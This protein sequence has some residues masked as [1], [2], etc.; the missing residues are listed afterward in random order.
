MKK[1]CGWILFVAFVVAVGMGFRLGCNHKSPGYVVLNVV[2]GD[3]I[4]IRAGGVEQS[5]RLLGVDTPETVHPDIP[6]EPY[7]AEAAEFTKQLLRGEKVV[8]RFGRKMR[9]RYGRL[10][11]FVYRGS[12]DLFVNL[13]IV[14]RGY[15]RV[16]GDGF[17]NRSLFLKAQREAQTAKMGIWQSTE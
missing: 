5:V 14:R 16:Y 12:D 15:G 4:K 9:D 3:T 10:L 1:A 7:G 17:P 2:D 13:E 6:P 11:A 8:L